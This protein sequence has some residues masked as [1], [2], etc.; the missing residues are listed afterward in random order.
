MIHFYTTYADD[1]PFFLKDTESLTEVMKV[2]DLFSSFSGLKP[3][4]SKC[5]VAGIGALN[6]A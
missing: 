5:E 4:K 6:R 2:F 3:N 1:I